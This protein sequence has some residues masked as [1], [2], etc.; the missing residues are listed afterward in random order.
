MGD[1]SLPQ[2]EAAVA[3]AGTAAARK[4]VRPNRSGLVGETK[5]SGFLLCIRNQS[6][7]RGTVL[8]VQQISITF[9]LPGSTKPRVAEEGF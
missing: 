8:K 6:R 2:V 4:E 7:S 3:A 5:I 9:R 1:F